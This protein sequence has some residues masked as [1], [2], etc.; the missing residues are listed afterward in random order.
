MD[1]CVCYCC[2]IVWLWSG[3]TSAD[4]GGAQQPKPQRVTKDAPVSVRTQIK[5]AKM[6]KSMEKSHKSSK[7]MVHN[8]YR[9]VK[10]LDYEDVRGVCV[11]E[12]CGGGGLWWYV[13]ASFIIMHG[14]GGGVVGLVCDG[15]RGKGGGRVLFVKCCCVCILW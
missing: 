9:R 12:F 7:K 1:V 5:Y 8:K 6:R 3:S 2:V 14:P 4:S 15:G 11:L 13:T 10:P